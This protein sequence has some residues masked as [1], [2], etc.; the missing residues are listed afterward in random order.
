MPFGTKVLYLR[1][2]NITTLIVNIRYRRHKDIDFAKW[3]QCVSNSIN[4]NVFGHVWY[5]NNVSLSW[6]GI[7]MDDYDAVMPVSRANS[8]LSSP[9]SDSGTSPVP[10]AAAAKSVYGMK[11]VE[12]KF[13]DP[14]TLP[15][16]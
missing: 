15:A 13:H 7:V 9:P 8:P 16:A 2:N 6:D 3:E 14:K 4:A 1:I 5:L 10:T 12:E 11:D